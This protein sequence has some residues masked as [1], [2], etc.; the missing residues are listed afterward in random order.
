MGLAANSLL[1][2]RQQFEGPGFLLLQRYFETEDGA[3]KYLRKVKNPLRKITTQQPIASIFALF[4]KRA[5]ENSRSHENTKNGSTA[6]SSARI[7]DIV[8]LPN[9]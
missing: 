1:C 9:K 4:S 7:F 3:S 8:R 2:K 5:C 6:S